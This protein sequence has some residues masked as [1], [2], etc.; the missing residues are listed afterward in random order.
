MKELCDGLLPKSCTCHDGETR[1][2]KIHAGSILDIMKE[3]RPRS[4]LCN[5]GEDEKPVQARNYRRTR[6]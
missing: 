4:C 1:L 5:E 2:E 6:S 3:C